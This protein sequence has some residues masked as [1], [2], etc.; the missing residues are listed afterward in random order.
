MSATTSSH[1]L[2]EMTLSSLWWPLWLEKSR[3]T[4]AGA[5][6]RAPLPTSP[7][8]KSTTLTPHGFAFGFSLF[9]DRFQEWVVMLL[10]SGGFFSL[11]G[12]LLVFNWRERR[13]EARR[14]TELGE[15]A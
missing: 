13:R 6:A 15:A 12:W 7:H 1:S 2:V 3:A 14:E 8:A 9:G 10:P 4:V 5:H 11:A